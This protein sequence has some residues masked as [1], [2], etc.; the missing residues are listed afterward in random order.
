MIV[1]Q[2]LFFTIV[3]QLFKTD[4]KLLWI[5]L[6]YHLDMARIL[7]GGGGDSLLEKMYYDSTL[8]CLSI[9]HHKTNA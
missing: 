1:I 2:D 3:I 9:S 5:L 8:G 7:G 6:G 4:I